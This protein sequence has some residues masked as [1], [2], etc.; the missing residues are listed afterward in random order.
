VTRKG[1]RAAGLLVLLAA[2][3][4]ASSPPDQP[5]PTQAASA[6]PSPSA[7]AVASPSTPPPVVASPSAPAVGLPVCG[8]A[9]LRLSVQDADSGAGQS[10][11]RLLLT[12]RGGACTLHGYPGVSFVDAQGRTLG[13]PAGKSSGA[14]RRVRI[15]PGRSVFAVLTYSNA[16][17]FP[18]STCR[19]TEADRVRV[20]P[21]GSKVALFEKDAVLVCAAPGSEQLHIGPL[22][23]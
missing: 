6:V 8:A 3:C 4:S 2:A 13:S 10:H 12:N 20:Y 18:D 9:Q 19:P 7:S 1:G 17:A 5:A 15:A 16:G 23:A 14:V 22:Q 11:Q 21:P